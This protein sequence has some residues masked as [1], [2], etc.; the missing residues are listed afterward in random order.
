MKIRLFNTSTY[1]QL[2]FG[3]GGGVGVEQ[4]ATLTYSHTTKSG[5]KSLH[6][7][8]TWPTDAGRWW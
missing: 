5:N 2:S 7:R 8:I 6:R 1:V 4:P 3:V